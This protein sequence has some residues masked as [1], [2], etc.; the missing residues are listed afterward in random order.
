[1][2]HQLEPLI[3]GLIKVWFAVKFL[4]GKR[5]S[6]QQNRP[7][8]QGISRDNN[9]FQKNMLKKPQLS[10]KNNNIKLA[11]V[12]VEIELFRVSCFIEFRPILLIK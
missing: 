5:E 6:Y 4:C 12:I 8:A 3:D 2:S 7:S 10:T 1:M 11:F 9:R